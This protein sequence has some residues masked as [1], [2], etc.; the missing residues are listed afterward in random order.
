MGDFYGGFFF[1][2]IS[3]LGEIFNL[4]LCLNVT[5]MDTKAIFY[6]PEELKKVVREC[7]HEW[8]PQKIEQPEILKLSDAAKLLCISPH[9]LRKH[10]KNNLIKRHLPDIRGYRFLYTELIKYKVYYHNKSSTGDGKFENENASEISKET[11]T[12]LSTLKKKKNND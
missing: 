2:K 4:I 1:F 5:V 7:L 10:A 12:Y 9:T 8:S 3:H 11:D 6:S